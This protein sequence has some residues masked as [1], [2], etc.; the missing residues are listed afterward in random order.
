M[1]RTIH[2]RIW[3]SF[4]L[5]FLISFLDFLISF[6]INSAIFYI[7]PIVLFSYQD[8]MAL[9]YS[10]LFSTVSAIM[11]GVFEVSS[12]PYSN[13]LY[14]FLNWLTRCIFF[15]LAAILANRFVVEITQRQIIS[16]QKNELESINHQLLSAN[17]E[18]NKFIGMAAHDIRNPV[19]SIQILSEMLLDEKSLSPEMKNLVEMIKTSADNSLHI[20][21]DTLNISKIQSGTIA[22]NIAKSNYIKFVQESLFLNNHLAER[23]R[24]TIK[25]ESALSSLEVDFDKT[26]LM[27]VIINLLT[28]AIKYSEPNTEITVKVGYSGD[29]NEFVLNR[30][31]D[32]GLGID[33][34]YHSTL[35]DPFTTTSNKPTDNESKTGLGLAIV[36][37]I[38]ELHKGTIGFTSEKGKGS[39]F[40]FS[41]PVNH[42]TTG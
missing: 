26:R 29:N 21:N 4:F 23:K 28:N 6:E 13:N 35:F 33:E 17:K 25:F 32:N 5:L 31:I 11:W 24:Q 27:Q 2:Q 8:R 30:V 1:I 22:L 16:T 39:E 20:L 34:K 40:F 15:F 3:A 10:I 36:K 12:N 42:Q 19:G 41:I 38:I 7:L 18:L 14:F 9:K 37:I